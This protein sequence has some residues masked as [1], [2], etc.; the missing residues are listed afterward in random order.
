MWTVF[1]EK[2]EIDKN[3]MEI[4]R[5]VKYT[6]DGSE[7]LLSNN[8][9]NVKLQYDREILDVDVHEEAPGIIIVFLVIRM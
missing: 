9:R 4:I 2:I 7:N 8:F 6:H 5:Q 3:Q 1:K